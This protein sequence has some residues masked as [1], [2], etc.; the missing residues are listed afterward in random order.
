MT[1]GSANTGRSSALAQ[2]DRL[3][4]SRQLAE[5]EVSCV[6]LLAGAPGDTDVW[7][8]L[9]HT[10]QQMA[11]YDGMRLAA[12]QATA[13]APAR[14][15]AALVAASAMAHC[16]EIEEA[17]ASLAQLQERAGDDVVALRH[18][19]DAWVHLNGFQQAETCLRRVLSRTP[20]DSEAL[21]ALSTTRVALGDLSE[22]EAL[23]NSVISK[24]RYDFDAL[25]NRSTLRR[26]TVERNHVPELERI[27]AS[28]LPHPAAE[29]PV[30]YA[31]S[32]ELEDLGDHRGAFRHLQIG[33]DLRRR[34]MAYRV[35]ADIQTLGALERAFP[36]DQDEKV[37]PA[38]ATEGPIFIVGLPR[39]GTTLV[40]RILSAHSSVASLGE[41]NDLAMAVTRLNYPAANKSDLISKSAQM[42]FGRLGDAYRR[43][44]AGYGAGRA[45]LIDKTP[46][47]FLYLG[48][49]AK[50]LP[51]ARIIH[52]RRHPM[53]V[54]HAMYKTLFRMG[55][56]FSYSQEDLGKYIA[57][58]LRLM[59]HWRRTMPGRFLDVDYE[60]LIDDQETVSRHILD[61]CGLS[62]E[63]ACLDF[64][65]N[66]SPSAT[67]SAAEKKKTERRITSPSPRRP[68]P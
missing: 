12:T 3:I 59:A 57:A 62:W 23:L 64:H 60:A 31:L 52:L 7:L 46:A 65:E 47:N 48:L 38:D 17:R 4:A 40:D 5:A 27:L 50:A 37:L 42:D 63:Q 8:R 49:I 21:Y 41:L 24:S 9:A 54:G 67:A 61:H 25:Y 18:I 28:R 33:A 10:R 29:V 11:N 45:W 58:Y 55:Y 20:D 13:S 32:K 19:A 43:A 15:D 44:V 51:E 39:S 53:A 2:L 1:A 66:A 34:Q 6:R 68:W 14:V 35:E 22:G 36:G 56:P 30:R 26:Q 16:G